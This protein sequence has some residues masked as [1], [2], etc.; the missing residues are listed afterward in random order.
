ME[1][2]RHALSL[3][4][5]RVV[6]LPPFYY[7][8]VSDDGIFAAYARIIEAVADPRLKLHPLPHPADLGRAAAQPAAGDAVGCGV[9]RHRRRAQGSVATPWQHAGPGGGQS[10]FCGDGRRRPAVVAVP[11]DR[12]RR[13]CITATSNLAARAL[14]TIYDHHADPDRAT[15][16]DAA[17][18]RIESNT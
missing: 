6:M 18:G 7:K 1:L 15:E 12:R 2:T 8:G 13:R 17:Q 9:S 16:V 5:T 14:R 11:Q 3:G 4:I 10:R